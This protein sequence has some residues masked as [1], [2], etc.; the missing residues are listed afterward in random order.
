[1][2]DPTNGAVLGS[3][4]VQVDSDAVRAQ[5]VVLPYRVPAPASTCVCLTFWGLQARLPH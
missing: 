1:M 4:S 2:F 5:C 3:G